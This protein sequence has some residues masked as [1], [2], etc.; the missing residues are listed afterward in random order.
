MFYLREKLINIRILDKYH[1]DRKK[2]KWIK[3]L[4]KKNKFIR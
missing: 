3:F 2:E 1:N 4:Q